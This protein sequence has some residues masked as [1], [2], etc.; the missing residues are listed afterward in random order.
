MVALMAGS[1]AA[2]LAVATAAAACYE[3]GYAFQ[4][5]E[6]RGV[7]ARHALRASLLGELARNAR[8][9]AATAL[10]LLGWP[11]QVA[12]LS[13]APLALVQ[14]TLA[15][16]LALLLVLGTRILGERVGRREL[17]AVAL[18]IAGIACLAAAAPRRGSV[19]GGTGL[20]LAIALLGVIAAAPYLVRG[21]SGSLLA[22]LSIGAADSVAALAA[23]LVAG[24]LGD[25]RWAVALVTAVVAALAG[26]LAT[27]SEMS[28]LQRLPA[29]RVAPI[30]MALQIAVP[31]VVAGAVGGEDWG[32]TALGGVV[33]AAGLLAVV[34]GAVLLAASPAVTALIAP[35]SS[36]PR[37]RP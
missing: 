16:G 35:P 19:T 18:V 23:K 9:L 21:R 36:A 37:R 31:V 8:W 3:T 15:L 30:V 14:P 4:A 25:G 1:T 27:V 2:G 12:A 32:S 7:S 29:T 13:L 11:L 26:V 28:A 17:A 6:A 33:V 34:A 10:S 24:Q 5:L 20:V 22:V